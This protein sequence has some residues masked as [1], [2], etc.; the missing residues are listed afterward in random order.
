MPLA[1]VVHA[2]RQP[3][4][5]SLSAARAAAS[6]RGSRWSDVGQS[7][8]SMRVLTTRDG[9]PARILDQVRNRTDT[10]AVVPAEAVDPGVRVLP[11]AGRHP[12]RDP[13]VY[14]LVIRSSRPV[15]EVT[16]LT[17]VGDVM[18][19]RRVGARMRVG[20]GP[21]V[22]DAAAGRTVGRRRD[23]ARQL[24]IDAVPGRIAHPGHGLFGADV[25]ARRR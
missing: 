15:P 25:T 3:A 8:G 19:A 17:A 18:L 11:V 16:N 2:T 12:L 20:G 6:G 4:D 10:L 1:L 21:Y 7:G 9:A 13:A 23:H 5:V 24:R 14:P 22:S